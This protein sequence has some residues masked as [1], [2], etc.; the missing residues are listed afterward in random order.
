[1]ENPETVPVIGEEHLVTR[2]NSVLV[3]M[4]GNVMS[5]WNPRALQREVVCQRIY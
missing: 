5:Q 2:G 1:M 3:G 4:R